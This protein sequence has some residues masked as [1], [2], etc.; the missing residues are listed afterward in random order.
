MAWTRVGV[1]DERVLGLIE[2]GR[3]VADA[4]AGHIY[5]NAP[6]RKRYAGKPI[7]F[8]EEHGYVKID[9]DGFRFMAHRAIWI[10]RHGV[11]SDDTMQINHLNGVKSDNRIANLELTSGLVNIRHGFATGLTKPRKGREIN[12]AKITEADVVAIRRLYKQGMPGAHIAPL[13]GLKKWQTLQIAQGKSWRHVREG[14]RE[15]P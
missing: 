7:G 11:P 12:T 15:V 8:L 4:D 13:F 9:I 6:Y 5:S 1:S 2:S 10:S 14:L 3:I